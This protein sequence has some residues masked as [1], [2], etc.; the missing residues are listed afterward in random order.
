VEDQ[1]ADAGDLTE[2]GSG[3][4]PDASANDADTAAAEIGEH[5]GSDDGGAPAVA[6]PRR[7]GRHRWFRRRTVTSAAASAG[8]VCEPE[9]VG[10]AEVRESEAVDEAE[11]AEEIVDGSEPA[12]AAEPVD[13]TEPAEAA[14]PV[15]GAQPAEEIVDGAEP[16]VEAVDAESEAV[17][18]AVAGESEDAA[19]TEE[20]GTA[21]PESKPV[22]RLLTAAVAA[23]AV[24]F[25][26][27]GAFAGAMLQP[28]LADR[29]VVHT[30]L[31]IARTAAN[32]ITTLW[33]YSPD[34]VDSLPDRA[35]KYL[36]GDFQAQYRKFIDAIAP[37]SKQAK[38][39][40]STQVVGT[41]VE[42]LSGGDATAVVYTNTTNSSPQSHNIPSM[43]YLSYRLTMQ[44]HDS[45]WLITKMTPI[46]SVDLT[47]KIG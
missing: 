11:P 41:A 37:M 17:G 35:A 39:T 10:G 40:N 45:R 8:E 14:E 43:L 7:G 46:T 19:Q 21:I 20:V 33:T 2:V 16:A 18:A 1:P 44:R 13:G 34:D 9:T 42:S 5:A 22:G 32:A 28:Y 4:E 30:K 38:V 6:P 15:D 26:G 3:S 12:E 25:V 23:A 31:D 29:A 47:P 36:G 27:A 24:V